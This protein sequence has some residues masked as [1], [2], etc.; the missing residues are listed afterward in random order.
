MK[1]NVGRLSRRFYRKELILG[2]QTLDKNKTE[3]GK[4]IAEQFW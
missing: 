3:I 1:L 4:N 2:L